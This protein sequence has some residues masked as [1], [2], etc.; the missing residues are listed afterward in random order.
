[1]NYKFFTSL[2]LVGFI[3]CKSDKPPIHYKE[4]DIILKVRSEAPLGWRKITLLKNQKFLIQDAGF[5]GNLYSTGDYQVV[6][7]TL[8]LEYS[9]ID[10]EFKASPQWVLI[11]KDSLTLETYKNGYFRTRK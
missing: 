8:K 5:D 2:L 11:S 6:D 7:D 9:F 4:S 3:T 1:M 10:P